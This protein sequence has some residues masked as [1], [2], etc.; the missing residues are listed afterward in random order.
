VPTL[1]ASGGHNTIKTLRLPLEVSN[2]CRRAPEK[3]KEKKNETEKKK[4][5]KL[6]KDHA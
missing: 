2:A 3:W 6:L 4:R 1:L 5:K